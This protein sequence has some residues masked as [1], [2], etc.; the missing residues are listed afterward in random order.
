MLFA[1]PFNNPLSSN[2]QKKT[3]NTLKL[4]RQTIT[5]ALNCSQILVRQSLKRDGLEPFWDFSRT[6]FSCKADFVT[7]SCFG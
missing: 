4:G 7:G 6:I 3:K 1:S 2:Q 5:Q